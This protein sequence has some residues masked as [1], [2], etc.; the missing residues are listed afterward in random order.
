MTLDLPRLKELLAKFTIARE[1]YNSEETHPHNRDLVIALQYE[2]AENDLAKALVSAA[3]D[4]IREIEEL[5]Q[6]RDA[7]IGRRLL[8]V[9]AQPSTMAEDVMWHE[10]QTLR[11][12]RD[13]LRAAVS[14]LERYAADLESVG[15]TDLLRKGQEPS[16]IQRGAALEIEATVI[17]KENNS[18]R[19]LIREA[20]AVVE[21]QRF[22]GGQTD[23]ER[24]LAKARTLLAET[25]A[26]GGKETE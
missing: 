1:A 3:P 11:A 12:E 15:L 26:R 19:A 10:I 7:T 24:W 2:G 25:V 5:R 9:G 23:A 13:E 8:P 14:R 16:D 6:H 4:L 17:Q 22:S 20:I 18:L 21:I